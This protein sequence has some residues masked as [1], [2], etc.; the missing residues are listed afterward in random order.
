MKKVTKLVLLVF[1]ILIVG[2]IWSNSMRSIPDSLEQS[3]RIKTFIENVLIEQEQE[4]IVN[5]KYWSIDNFRKL[6]HF[7]EFFGLSMLITTYIVLFKNKTRDYLLAT[8]II[9]LA[10][11]DEII[12]VFS[13]RGPSIKD[14]VIDCLGGLFGFTITIIFFYVS[15]TVI[16]YI[17]GENKVST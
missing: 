1:I 13:K 7:I 10:A 9:P 11:M 2:Y 16:R 3:E 5:S 8:L 4:E 12:Q 14:V 17:K 6:A 15:T